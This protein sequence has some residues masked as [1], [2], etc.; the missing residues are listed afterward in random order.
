ADRIS[1]GQTKRVAIGRA[2]RAGA[3]ILFLDEPLAGVDGK[4]ILTIMELL[5]FLAR[6]EQ[7]TLVIVE[8]VVNIPRVLD[9]ADTVWT[10]RDPHLII[11]RPSE[12]RNQLQGLSED[13]LMPWLKSVAGPNADCE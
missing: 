7:V 4:G 13:G 12:V 8:H 2:V 1:L 11:E 5:T 10:L 6:D 3:R 9:L